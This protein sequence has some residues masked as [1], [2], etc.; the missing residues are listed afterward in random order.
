MQLGLWPWDM[1]SSTY[2]EVCTHACTHTLRWM[3]GWGKRGLFSFFVRRIL[4]F[5]YIVFYFSVFWG[6]VFICSLGWSRILY[7]LYYRTSSIVHNLSCFWQLPIICVNICESVV[8]T[9]Y[10]NGPC[11]IRKVT[12]DFFGYFLSV[13]SKL[14]LFCVWSSVSQAVVKQCQR[15]LYV[16][17]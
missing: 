14:N 11:F 15:L 7:Y 12:V 4:H 9:H 3:D 17:V 13:K 6:R 1:A 10:H 2:A 5:L 8:A 16:S